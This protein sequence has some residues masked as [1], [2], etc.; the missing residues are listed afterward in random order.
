MN[1]QLNQ[2]YIINPHFKL[3]SD[4][5][6]VLLFSDKNTR[7]V[8]NDFLS[9]IHPVYAIMLSIFDGKSPLSAVI[10]KISFLLRMQASIV[11]GF[12]YPLIENNRILEFTFDGYNMVLPEM[13][14]INASPG[15]KPFEYN[16]QDFFI[17]K[18]D[19]DME[20][21]RLNS[22]IDALFMV[23]TKCYTDCIYCY[24]DRRKTI[25]CL[26]PFERL[27]EIVTE[28]RDIGMS[29]FDLTGGELFLYKD[30]ERLIEILI[31]KGFNPYISTKCPIDRDTILKLKSLGIERIQISIDSIIPEEMQQIV[32]IEKNYLNQ[33]LTTLHT[34]ES[35]NM[36]IY[37]NTQ[38][39]VINQFHIEA[40]LMKLLSLRT[41]KRINIGVVGFS[42][43]KGENAFSHL[44][45]SLE[46]IK[47]IELLVDGLK[48]KHP[49]G[50]YINFS[51]YINGD[52]IY[53]K[54]FNL[55]FFDF[56]I[57]YSICNVL[58]HST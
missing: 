58:L 9:F 24:A 57:V 49:Q 32:Q 33:I 13:I 52:N 2:I 26:I 10:E 54:I 15:I 45:P 7:V 39:S 18:Q 6:R 30:W 43:Y 12:I 16:P 20:S 53:E 4:R 41:V 44:K 8:S 36:Q 50:S 28:A 46:Q 17:A 38:I 14:I 19:L 23:N 31:T 55:D 1:A 47:Q 34:L 22:P 42:L 29:T 11:E 51:G 5:N 21:W 3:K 37:T 56:R 25:D 27:K 40:L 35:E 48:N